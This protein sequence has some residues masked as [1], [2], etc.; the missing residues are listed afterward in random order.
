MK[1]IQ[2][3]ALL[4]V[5]LLVLSSQVFAQKKKRIMK[6]DS[7]LNNLVHPK[8]YQ[9]MPIDKV[10]KVRKFGRGSKDMILIAGLG[11]ASEKVFAQFIKDNAHQFTMYTVTL[12]GYGGTRAYPMPP[13][14]TSYAELTWHKY[15]QKVITHLIDRHRMKKPVIVVNSQTPTLIALR[16]AIDTPEKV[17]AVIAIGGE[18][19]RTIMPGID[20]ITP[21]Q[22]KDFIDKRMAPFWFKTVTDETWDSN[23]WDDLIYSS[24]PQNGQRLSEAINQVPLRFLLRYMIEHWSYDISTEL[25]K[26]RVPVLAIMPGFSRALDEQNPK[27]K[28]YRTAFIDTWKKAKNKFTT[29][30]VKNAGIFVHQDQPEEVNKL[31]TEFIKNL[32]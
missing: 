10:G 27:R 15:S 1:T 25:D 24:N 3:F 11:L 23:M 22:R 4:G 14:G 28:F 8:G 18:F 19:V 31:I 26:I 7:T 30:L 6:Q 21:Q 29:Q 5:I 13:R 12:A 17:G 9:T 16:M 20:N 32:K 2:S